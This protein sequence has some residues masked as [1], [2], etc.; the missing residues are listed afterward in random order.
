MTREEIVKA[1]A[2]GVPDE[3]MEP[4]VPWRRQAQGARYTPISRRTS[5]RRVKWLL[6]NH[7]EMKDAGLMRLVGTTKSTIDAVRGRHPLEYRHC[8]MD[9]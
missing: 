6:R 5:G 8:A 2:T 3:V 4:K 1:E 7:P 9:R